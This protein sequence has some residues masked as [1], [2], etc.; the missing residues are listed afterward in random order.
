MVNKPASCGG[1]PLAPISTGFMAPSLATEP[2]GVTLIGEALGEDEAEAGKPFVGRAGFRLNRL[3]EWAGYSRKQFDIINTAWCRPPDNK[4]EGTP[5]EIPAIAHCRQNHWQSLLSRSRVL[6]PMGNVPTGAL[7]GRKGILSIRGYFETTDSHLVIP[8]VHPSF[9]QRGQS[10]WSA[11]FIHDIQKA[12]LAATDGIPPQFTD[13]L[14]DPSPLAAYEWA[15]G[16]RQ[17][18]NADPSIRLA[19][20]IETPGKGDEEDD[21][22]LEGNDKTWHIWRIGFSYRGLSAL[23]IPW[24]PAYIPA[25]KMVLGSPGDKVVWNAGFDV[26]RVRRAGVP[27]AGVIH[28]AMVAWHIL[29]SDLPK[30]LKFVATFTCPWQPA[31]KHLSGSKPA[32]YNAIDADVEWLS[33]D[34]IERELRRTGL[35]DVYERDVVDLEPILVHMREAGMRVDGDVRRDRAV[36]LNERLIQSLQELERLTPIEARRIAH[37]YVST[38]KRTEGLLS[39]PSDREVSCCTVCGLEKPRKDHFKLY[40]KKQNR[41]AGASVVPRIK[42]VDEYYRLAEFTPSRD[43]LIRYHNVLNRPLPMVW[44]KKEKRK[45]ISFNEEQIKKLILAY[46]LDPLYPLVLQ[47]RSY[48]K[49]AGTYLGRPVE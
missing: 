43:Q 46:P 47:Y 16:Y 40:V 44:D 8:T 12:V 21:L 39:R 29:H 14:L 13:Y 37:V 28:D 41:C 45:K 23:S 33:M 24:E 11:A 49:L 38:P 20:D 36:K 3:L 6:V 1:C 4:L 5:Y 35:W 31:W 9:I 10:K 42:R 32:Y 19:F 34:V 26:P 30:S 7:L 25:I 48:D 18:L 2:L 15:K 22:D 27:I 17:A